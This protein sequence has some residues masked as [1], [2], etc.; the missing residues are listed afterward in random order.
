[1]WIFG[2][3]S[4]EEM[5]KIKEQGW[6]VDRML[7]TDEVDQFVKPGDK[8]THDETDDVYPL[9]YVESDVFANLN[10]WNGQAEAYSELD[11]RN[12][13][14]AD[15]RK[16]AEKAWD[17]FDFYGFP[18]DF[19]AHEQEIV[20][21]NGWEYDTSLNRWERKFFYTS[22]IAGDPTIVGT[23]VVLFSIDSSAIIDTCVN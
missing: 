5:E 7:T 4:K 14:E 9:I 17:D 23:F 3:V 21:S 22:N 1:M 11:R 13:L 16:A 2:A 19:L 15:C 10:D 18:D 20:E 6:Q 8:G 12:R